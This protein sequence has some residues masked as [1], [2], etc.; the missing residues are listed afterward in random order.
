MMLTPVDTEL[1]WLDVEASLD[2]DSRTADAI[3]R[4]AGIVMPDDA[5]DNMKLDA[6]ET[7]LTDTANA[8]G[9]P[10][11]EVF[12]A[13]HRIRWMVWSDTAGAWPTFA[14]IDGGAA[15]KIIEETS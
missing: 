11:L 1:T 4:E 8:L 7:L 15:V 6:I 5:A 2:D 3:W 13:R 10:L 12:P 14:S 9:I